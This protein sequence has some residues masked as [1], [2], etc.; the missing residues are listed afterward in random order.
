MHTVTTVERLVDL[1][2]P[3]ANV[4]LNMTNEAAAAAVASGDPDRVRAIDGQFAIIQKQGNIVRLARSIGRPMRYFLAKQVAGPCLIVAER[5]EEIKQQLERDGLGDQ[6]H[7]SYTRMVPAHHL[8]EILLVGC[9]DPNPTYTRYFT[10]ERNSLSKDIDEIGLAYMGA[11]ADECR[12]WL[13][14]IDSKE[15]IGV[16]FSGGIDSG[17]VFLLLYHLLLKRGES[18]ARL[19]AF[20]L[21]VEGGDDAQQA[22]QFL[23]HLDLSMFLE[24]ID[25]PRDEVDFRD[26][27]RAIED[28]KPLDV[29]S[30][31]M[32]FALCRGIRERYPDWKYLVDGDGGDENL[33]DYPIEE[34]SELT[35]RSVLNN[36]MLYQEG[37]GVDAIKHSLVFSG[38]Q[39]RGHVRSYA[40]GRVLGFQGFSPYALPNVID[41][42]ESIPFIELT[43]WDHDRLY[44]LKGE[45][46]RR[47]I[48]SITG[49]TMPVYEKRRFQRGATDETGFDALF[50]ADE[51]AYRDA[52]VEIFG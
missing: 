13:D 43:D 6:F 2:D 5:M 8:V 7:P 35:I 36:L 1:I 10:P 22:K 44:A 29:Q 24:V 27:I 52:F 37:W 34:N 28:Y 50:P 30:A 17:A 4:L 49:L 20:T 16:L 38:G 45:I 15:P 19:K 42:A 12:K 14:R 32:A 25:V 40:P 31:T 26:A 11:L 18:P 47:G 51:A 3:N 48:E 41:V 33:K 46:T 9:P 21:S 23:E 39:S